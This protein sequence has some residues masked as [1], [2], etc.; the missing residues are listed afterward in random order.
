MGSMPSG[1]LV[2]RPKIL[3]SCFLLCAKSAET[4]LANASPSRSGLDDLGRIEII[5]LV[6]LGAGQKQ[7]PGMSPM[8]WT[9][10]KVVARIPV[11]PDDRQFGDQSIG[12]LR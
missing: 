3:P 10:P 7:L 12:H 9:S 2:A 5:E 11:V 4:N 6:T 1:S 8:R